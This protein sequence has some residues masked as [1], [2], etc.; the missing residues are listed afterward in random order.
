MAR[1]LLRISEN[2]TLNFVVIHY[3]NT[4]SDKESQA[5]ATIREINK[6]SGPLIL[7]GDFNSVPNSTEITS[8]LKETGLKDA[9]A[10]THNGTHVPTNIDGPIDYIFYRQTKLQSC[11]EKTMEEISDHSFVF[12][13]FE[14]L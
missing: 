13:S 6:L 7:V 4:D 10:D 3:G 9:Y 12:A 14:L 2:S 8:L 11:Y 5:K 1:S